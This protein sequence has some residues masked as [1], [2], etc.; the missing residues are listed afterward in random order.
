MFQ[1]LWSRLTKYLRIVEIKM[2][3]QRMNII[4][5]RKIIDRL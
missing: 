1:V 5:L 4:N 3:S 2:L